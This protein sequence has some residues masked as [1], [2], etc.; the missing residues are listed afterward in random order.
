MTEKGL[1]GVLKSWLPKR[2]HYQPIESSSAPGI[3]DVNFCLNGG[4]HWVELKIVLGKD[5][6]RF[7]KPLSPYQWNW[8]LSRAKA[9]GSVWVV[10]MHGTDI[11]LYDCSDL[12]PGFKGDRSELPSKPSFRLNKNERNLIE[13]HLTRQSL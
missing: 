7:Q 1:R 6:L 12:L 10:G 11:L 5:K 4:D 9:G 8:L 13:G 2:T 3:P